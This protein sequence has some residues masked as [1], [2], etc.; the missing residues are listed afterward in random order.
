MKCIIL[1]P[2]LPAIVAIA[3]FIL[4]G[5]VGTTVYSTVYV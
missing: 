4:W 5:F 3:Y 1:F 2:V